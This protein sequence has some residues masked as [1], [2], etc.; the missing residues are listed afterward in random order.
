MVASAAAAAS[1]ESTL[2][3]PVKQ[4]STIRTRRCVGSEAMNSCMASSGI[5]VSSGES[6]RVS[7]AARYTC[8]RFRS[9]T[10]RVPC[11]EK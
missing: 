7:L 9:S 11:P 5:A 4:A 8:E 3:T 6:L 2:P 10:H 1:S